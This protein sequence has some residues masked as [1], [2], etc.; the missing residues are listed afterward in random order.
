MAVD[1]S[2]YLVT[3]TEQVPAG[4]QLDRVV[5]EAIQGGVTLVQLREKHADTRL[6]IQRASAVKAVCDAHRVPLLINDRVDVA[7]AVGA[8]GVHVGQDDMP[9]AQVRQLLPKGSIVGVSAGTVDEALEAARAGADYLGVGA[10]WATGSK[11]VA[12]EKV[13]GTSIRNSTPQP[14]DAM[15]DRSA[16]HQANTGRIVLRG[17]ANACRSD[18]CAA[19][20]HGR[21]GS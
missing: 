15:D 5:G 2:L 17:S 4:S 10:C 11:S 1:L 6:F 21:S 14:P 9:I 8:A 12:D 3:Q 16:R 7:L 20:L 13:L 18:W 19:I